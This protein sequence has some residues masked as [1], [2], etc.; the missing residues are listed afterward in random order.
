MMDLQPRSSGPRGPSGAG[1][2]DALY[3]ASPSRILWPQRPGRAIEWLLS[4]YDVRDSY[5]L[6]A[7]CGDGKNAI[8]LLHRGAVVRAFDES[9]L[10]IAGLETNLLK[11]DPGRSPRYSQE[12]L[13]EFLS[14]PPERLFD[15]VVS[16][17][18]Y[19]CLDPVDRFVSHQKLQRL[20]RPDGWLAFC[21]L[22]ND[23][24]MPSYHLTPSI[25]L[26]SAAEC[27]ELAPES[28]WTIARSELGTIVEKHPPL[29]GRHRHS[30]C[31]VLA[32][33]R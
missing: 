1:A 2:Y 7:G 31:W 6:D 5:V 10:A 20:V 11:G 14:V 30:A 13:T 9:A 15:V 25:V 24:P 32:R 18:L 23:L 4:A 17:G 26:P 33:R 19:H 27:L 28:R 12:S 22:T 3:G 16:Y 21:S 29:V 8:P